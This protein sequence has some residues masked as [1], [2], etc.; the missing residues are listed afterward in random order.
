M[1]VVTKCIVFRLEVT[2][3]HTISMVESIEE[4]RA[5]FKNANMERHAEVVAEL[6]NIA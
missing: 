2:I 3:Y 4:L 6:K 5:I 1:I